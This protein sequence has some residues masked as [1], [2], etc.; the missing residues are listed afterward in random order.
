MVEKIW[1]DVRNGRVLVISSKQAGEDAPILATPTTTAQKR[2]PDRT[3][4][5]D[6]RIISDLG[7][8]NLS[9]QKEDFPEVH[10]ADVTKIAERALANKLK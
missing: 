4:S 8:P 1:K 9:C 7:F 6:F 5:T 10:L 2:L 3:L